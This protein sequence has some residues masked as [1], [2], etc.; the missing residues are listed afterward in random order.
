MLQLNWLSLN[1]SFKDSSSNYCYFKRYPCFVI[2]W[3]LL[4][5]SCQTCV[6]LS[7]NV[8]GL[9]CARTLNNTARVSEAMKVLNEF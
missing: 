2:F 8:S 1:L 5:K 3:P 4:T 6:R 9:K 7:F